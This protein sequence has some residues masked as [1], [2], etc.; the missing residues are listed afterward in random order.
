MMVDGDDGGW[1]VHVTLTTPRGV[2]L[3]V[4]A[5]WLSRED[6]AT[7]YQKASA[8]IGTPAPRIPDSLEPEL[9]E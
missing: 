5:S 3:K 6:A 2:T 7:S 9:A 4:G 1:R 8:A